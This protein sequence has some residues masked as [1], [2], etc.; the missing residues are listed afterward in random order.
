MFTS[1]K[2]KHDEL[3]AEIL[4]RVFPFTR[5]TTICLDPPSI[6]ERE[7]MM[8]QHKTKKISVSITVA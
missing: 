8:H 3:C 6:A 2:A 7:I 4:Y 1:C 5:Q